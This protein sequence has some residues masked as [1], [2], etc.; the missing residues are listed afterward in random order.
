[1]VFPKININDFI[2]KKLYVK[3]HSDRLG[4]V[5]GEVSSRMSGRSIVS[6]LFRETRF[7]LPCKPCQDH[8]DCVLW[9]QGPSHHEFVPHGTPVNAKFYVEV[10]KR[11]IL[12]DSKTPT[13]PQPLYRSDVAPPEFFLFSRLKT[14][15][16]EHHFGTVLTQEK[17]ILKPFN[18]LYRSVQ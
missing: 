5:K 15:M 7:C 14:P 3:V 12:A 8:A 9:H 13:I 10:L 2:V 1:M 6:R 11:Q 18:V 17:P 4:S 16:K